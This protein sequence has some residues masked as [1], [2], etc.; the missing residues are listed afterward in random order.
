[1]AWVIVERSFEEPVA[2]QTVQER[3]EAVAWCM[4]VHKVRFVRSFFSTDGRRMVC[5][6]EAPDAEAVRTAN[7]Q[8]GNPFD[9]IW[10]T[11]IFEPPPEAG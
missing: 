10:T 9:R 8:S 7:R 6:Y 1:M 3:E 2:F 5:L 4:E 11:D